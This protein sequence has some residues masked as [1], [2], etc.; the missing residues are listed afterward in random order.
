MSARPRPQENFAVFRER[1]RGPELLRTCERLISARLS[2]EAQLRE[3]KGD[4][5][6]EDEQ[7]EI[8]EKRQG[9]LSGLLR[10]SLIVARK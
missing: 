6:F 7:S 2:Y 1:L 9:I 5:G 4:Q 3:L 8:E 10:R